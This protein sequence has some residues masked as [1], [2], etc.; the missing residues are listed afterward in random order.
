MTSVAIETDEEHETARFR[1]GKLSNEQR[2]R[3][4]RAALDVRDPDD[5]N[6][7]RLADALGVTVQTVNQWINAKQAAD[8]SRWLSICFVLRLP[9]IWQEGDPVQPEDEVPALPPPR[10]RSRPR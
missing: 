1:W 10:R 9:P 2:G 4:I 8:F 5:G 6:Q 3:R 7:T